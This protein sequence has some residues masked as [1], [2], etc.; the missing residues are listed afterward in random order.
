M[1]KKFGV[2]IG[3]TT[4]SANETPIAG[5]DVDADR[6]TPSSTSAQPDETAKVTE[7][8]RDGLWFAGA[9]DN[10]RLVADRAKS[11]YLEKYVVTIFQVPAIELRTDFGGSQPVDKPK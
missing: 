1:L 11:R 9:A 2:E 10:G 4:N 6:S 7:K 5:N 3:E 8:F